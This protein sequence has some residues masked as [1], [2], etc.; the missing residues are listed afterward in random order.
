MW[1]QAEYELPD[2]AQIVDVAGESAIRLGEHFIKPNLEFL[3]LQEATATSSIWVEASEETYDSVVAAE[4]RLLIDVS[5]VA[6][7][8]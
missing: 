7:A 2:G 1:V 4:R 3:Q 6:G 5:S 8:T